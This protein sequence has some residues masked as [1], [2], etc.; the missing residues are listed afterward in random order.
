MQK[1]F[2]NYRDSKNYFKTEIKIIFRYGLIRKPG[3]F[4]EEF[5]SRDLDRTCKNVSYFAQAY[6][7]KMANFPP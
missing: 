4:R 5:S 6:N 2:T 1:G 7:F 3:R